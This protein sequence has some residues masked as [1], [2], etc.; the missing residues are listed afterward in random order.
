MNGT[1]LLAEFRRSRSDK[2][3]GELV[4]RYTN[5]V[6]SATRRRLSNDAAAEEATQSVFIRLASAAPELRDDAALVAW[7]HRTAVHV[8]ID[9]WR[10][11][12]RRRAREEQ[13]AAMQTLADDTAWNEIAPEIDEALNK[14][15]DS[16]RQTILLRIFERKSMRELGAAFGISEDAAKMRVSRA[17]ERLREGMG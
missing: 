15:T 17:L 3:F 1:D 10:A 4:R 2:A 14:L 11:E 5:L 12:S 16:E 8:S 6:Y 9:L 13:A 7:L